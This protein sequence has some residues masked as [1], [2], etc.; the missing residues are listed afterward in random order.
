MSTANNTRNHATVY[1]GL[2]RQVAAGGV[3]RQVAVSGLIRQVAASGVISGGGRWYIYIG[4]IRQVLQVVCIGLIREVAGG[5][6]YIH[7]SH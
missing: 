1:S 2:I 4:L 7:W 3:I 5:G 6:I